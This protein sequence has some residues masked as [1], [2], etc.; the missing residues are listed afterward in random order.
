MIEFTKLHGNGNDFIVIDEFEN[1]IVPENQKADFAVKY[2]RRK[3]G[4]GADGILYIS[5]S[6]K[7]D[8]KMRLLQPD[9]SE[10]EMCGNGIRCL[11]KYAY[12]NGYINLGESTVETIADVYNVKT[13]KDDGGFW[14]KVNMGKPLT[15]RSDIPAQG[16]SDDDFINV[17]LHDYP[18]SVVNTGVPHA[19]IFVENLDFNIQNTAPKIRF[20]E[21]FP[22]G[23]NVNFVRIDSNDEITIRT[24]ERGV[25][26]ETLSC[27]TG[28][29]ASAYISNLLG[30]VNNPVLV[31]TKGGML[32]IELDGK[33]FLY[34]EGPAETIYKGVTFK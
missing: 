4:I 27:G 16:D 34:M 30:K 3:F 2:C 26:D 20:D 31:H 22:N 15:K 13:R 7:A 12:D 33:G 9:A 28:S 14:V 18:V 17:D 29:V 25:E 10:A 5:G 19:V 23:A 21:T 6:D 1:E 24:Y 8:M 11:V 32:N